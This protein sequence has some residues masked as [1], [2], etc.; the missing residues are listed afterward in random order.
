MSTFRFCICAIALLLVG[1]DRLI[2]Y[3]VS[4]TFPPPQEQNHATISPD[5]P[6]VQNALLIIDEVIAPNGFIR[7]TNALSSAQKEQDIIATYAAGSVPV[8]LKTN[9]LDITFF[10][11]GP[12]R[13]NPALK[14]TCRT[15]KDKLGRRYGPERVTTK[16]E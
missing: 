4:L 12:H 15:I 8:T 9:T 7:D 13:P 6:Q 10:T 16:I 5:N 2:H 14:Q 1:C 3:R 11:F